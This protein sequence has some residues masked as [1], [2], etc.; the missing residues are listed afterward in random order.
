MTERHLKIGAIVRTRL[1]PP[2]AVFQV[3]RDIADKIPV[4][5]KVGYKSAAG[6]TE[7]KDAPVDSDE[8]IA[9]AKA[10]A[11]VNDQIDTLKRDFTFDYGVEAWSWDDGYSWE[12]EA[13]DSWSFPE[14]FT[15]Y[16]LKPGTN[17]RVDYIRYKLLLLNDDI[18]IVQSDAT[19]ATLPITNQEVSAAL[20]GFPGDLEGRNTA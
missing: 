3:G 17:K 6:H 16:G 2:Y 5:P 20:D 13:P 11:V 8:F 12:T 14:M 15:R 18:A 9:Y 19:G 4:P 10:V 1:V 7:Y